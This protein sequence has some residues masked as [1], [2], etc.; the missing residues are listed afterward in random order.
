VTELLANFHWLRPEWLVISALALFVELWRRRRASSRQSLS[1]A[2]APHLREALTLPVTRWRWFNPGNS[3]LLLILLGG[4]VAAGPSW[5]QQPSP[6]SDDAAALVIL[7][8][9]S[10]SMNSTDVAP[11]RLERS[12][13]KI[14]DLLALVPDK[15]VGLMVFAGSAHVVLPLTPDHDILKHYLASLHSDMMPRPGKHAEYAIPGLTQMLDA[16]QQPAD[17]LLIT[18]GLAESTTPQITAWLNRTGHGL[19]VF[20]IGEED[21]PIPLQRDSLIALA[22]ATD[23]HLVDD[24]IDPSDVQAIKRAL[25]QH[26]RIRDDI[27]LPWEDAGYWLVWPV[28]ILASLWFRRGWTP[29]WLLLVLLLPA[30]NSPPTQAQQARDFGPITAQSE[31]AI[32]EAYRP[33]PFE[34]A[35]DA[36]IG[37]WLTNDQY[38]RLLLQWGYYHKAGA[39]FDDPRW[40]ATAAYYQ[41]DFSRAIALLTTLEGQ[42]AAFAAANARAHLRDYMGA[43]RDYS[44][45]LTSQPDWAAAETNRKIVQQ[46]IDEIDALSA[47]QPDEPGTSG[48]AVNPE[49]G[50]PANGSESE[51]DATTQPTLTAEQLLASPALAEQWLRGV[52]QDPAQFLTVKFA[53]QLESRGVSE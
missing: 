8:D 44:G 47:S 49:D 9:V 5:R 3:L 29:L 50:A 19:T 7:L 26:Y 24:S 21:A 31:P 17:I 4:L 45:L 37:L 23:A 41:Q 20:A 11:S 53:K 43:R 2:I 15:R 16:T 33:T 28:L 6:L 38:G 52:Q 18:D 22:D 39:T 30:L 13:Q 14:S 34:A 46:L 48:E 40:I 36:F 32:H 25:D 35:L 27:A 1:D 51:I 12:K 42:S 10:R